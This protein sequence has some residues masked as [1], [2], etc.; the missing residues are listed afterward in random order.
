LRLMSHSI[1]LGGEAICVIESTAADL[2]GDRGD[3]LGVS[4]VLGAGER[5]A[6][7]GVR[8]RV[9]QDFDGHVGDVSHIAD[10]RRAVA[11]GRSS[12]QGTAP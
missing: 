10:G 2:A 3:H 6:L 5:I 7:T 1:T 4:E 11:S 12:P 9:G 8:R